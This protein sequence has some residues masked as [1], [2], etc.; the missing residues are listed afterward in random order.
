MMTPII[1][2]VENKMPGDISRLRGLRHLALRVRDIEKAKA[3]YI[4]FFGMKIVWE[5]DRQNCYVSSGSDNLALHEHPN[6]LNA[7]DA[8]GAL[9]HF[10]FVA[11]SPAAVDAWAERAKENGV[12]II[13]PPKSHRDGSYSC[14]VTDPDGN[15]VQI[16]YEPTLSRQ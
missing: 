2:G 13:N 7:A 1:I 6:V 9:D 14:Y 10:G 11:E 4:E 16:I 15:T 5:P 3:F 8:T 12:Q